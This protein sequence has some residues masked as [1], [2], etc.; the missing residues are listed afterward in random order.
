MNVLH[1]KYAV[2]IANT[3]SINK[4]AEKLMVA[5]PNLS[6]SIKE[7][8]A[9]FG[10]SIFDR[11]VKGM[12][13]TPE[14]EEFIGYAKKI[15][16]QIDDLEKL[17]K[18]EKVSNKKKF[19][20]SVP[21]ASY[22]SDAFATFS[23]SIS[24]EPCEIVYKETNALRAIKNIL[25]AEYKL[26]IIRYAANY[27]MYFKEMLEEKELDFELVAEF[28]YVIVASRKSI[29]AKKKE[30]HFEDLS[31]LVE[32]AHAD[33]YVPALSLAYVRKEELP[34]DV[35]RRIFVFERGS[36][37]ELLTENSETYMWVSPLPTK[38]LERFNLVQI[39]CKDNQKIYKDLLIYKKNYKM[40]ELDK[41]FITEVCT[42]RRK[43]L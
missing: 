2:E 5:Q 4:A 13:L 20:I 42:S 16:S 11:S 24:K 1:M 17:Y 35:E 27:D 15:L 10:V 19:S 30:V 38:V 32:I 33:P 31:S 41:L 29:L 18:E 14:G 28:H 21:R 40:T 36:Q 3:G 12:V 43:Y 9:D 23:K 39:D 22:I 26:G 34:E 6:R 25:N 37:F 8:E 7:L